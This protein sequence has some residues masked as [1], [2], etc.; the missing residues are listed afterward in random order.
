LTK[1][2]IISKSQCPETL[3]RLT[4]NTGEI[5][6]V[7]Y[8][9]NVNRGLDIEQPDGEYDGELITVEHDMVRLD[10]MFKPKP[11]STS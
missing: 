2:T 7:I 9:M 6:K 5:A 1:T 3:K 4:H 10:I 11:S 8:P